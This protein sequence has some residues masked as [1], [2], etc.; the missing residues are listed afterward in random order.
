MKHFH[1][2]L[3]NALLMLAGSS[4]AYEASIPDAPEDSFQE[5]PVVGDT[6]PMAESADE[7]LPEVLTAS[8]LRQPKSRTPGTVTILEGDML[9]SLGVLNL[10]D[11]FRLVPGMTVGYVGSNNPVVS[12]HGTVAVEQRRLQVLVDGRSYYNASLADVDWNNIPVPMEEIERIEVTRGPNAAAYGANSFLAVINIVTRSPQETHGI[13]ARAVHGLHGDDGF[14]H[15]YGSAGGRSGDTDWR[16]SA[17]VRR[18]DGFDY[19]K[20]RELD[21][22]GSSSRTGERKEARDGFDL[23]SLNLSTQ[24]ELTAQD[25]I[26]IRAGYH[27][28]FE[29]EDPTELASFRPSD[30][31]DITGEDWYGSIRWD[32]SVS[33]DHFFHV[34]AYY[35]SRHR[36]QSWRANIDERIFPALEALPVD[37]LQA[38]LNDD[39]K[40]QRTHLEFQETRIWSPRARAVYGASYREERY[41]SDT[42]FNG[43]E[44]SNHAQV[45]AN[46]ERGLTS[47]LTAN[48]GGMWEDDSDHG[49]FFSPRGAANVHLSPNQALRFVFSKAHRLPDAFESKRDWQ[50]R[51]ANV[52]PEALAE[53]LEGQRQGPRVS[54]SNDD[55]GDDLNSETIIS[56][57]IS[58]LIQQRRGPNLY[59]AEAK[60]FR[61][62]LRDLIS[63]RT[64]IDDW[65]LENAVA[66]TQKGFELEAS[67]DTPRNMVRVSYAYLDSDSEYTGEPDRDPSDKDRFQRLEQRMNARHSGSL[68]WIHRLSDDATG[69]ISYYLT[70]SLRDR[71]FERL[72]LR[73]AKSFHLPQ[74]T[75]EVAGVFQ[76]YLNDEPIYR[77]ANNYSDRNHFYA[78]VSVR[79]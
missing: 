20:E 68:A 56:R 10:W 4:Q 39:L 54:A 11:A 59:Q 46:L 75:M 34:K 47:W 28:V 64:N 57:E 17:N 21:E 16:L 41:E 26:S 24:S 14:R 1:F 71:R 40:E 45:F 7:S 35:Q 5:Q 2:A 52:S 23:L 33:A 67:A 27:D 44:S 65:D 37:E 61:D 8:R 53:E 62:S 43:T 13:Q 72:D 49:T 25:E 58:Y 78:E 69:A 50:Y 30:N 55:N 77:Q 15:Y 51:P 74:S 9:R 79:F 63:G 38:D 36:R 31:P 66:V 70:D 12:Y 60:V 3:M 6:F 48:V 73:L 19:R 32:H 76:H 42:F 29:E 18:T 22:D